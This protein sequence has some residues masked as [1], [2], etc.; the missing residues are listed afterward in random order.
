[1]VSQTPFLQILPPKYP[2]CRYKTISF[3][4]LPTRKKCRHYAASPS[5]KPAQQSCSFRG[6]FYTIPHLK[7]TSSLRALRSNPEKIIFHFIQGIV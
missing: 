7:C 2:P 6:G 3:S 5:L 1:M 4:S